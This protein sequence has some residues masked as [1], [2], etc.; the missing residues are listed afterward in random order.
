MRFFSKPAH[1]VSGRD[2]P[3]TVSI[4]RWLLATIL[5]VALALR[6]L[7]LAVAP[8]HG[9]II[10][11]VEYNGIAAM[12]ND[13]RGW[14]WFAG[15]VW[16]RPPLYPLFLLGLYK[17]F[18]TNMVAFQLVQIG[19]SVATVWLLHLWSASLY[20]R[21]VGLWAAGLLAVA[22]P[23]VTFPTFL[24]SENLFLFLLVAAFLALTHAVS[25]RR[26][27]LWALG[28]GALL[29]CAALT[30][31]QIL[32]F[33]PL[34]LLWP[35][36]ACGGTLRE[37]GRV[38]L[39]LSPAVLLAFVV[40]IAPWLVRNATTY[41][42]PFIDST[43]GYN[44]YL[45]AMGAREEL[46]VN[47]TLLAEPNQAARENLA[48]GKGLEKLRSDPAAFV[49]K[50]VK[51]FGDFWRLN[52]GADENLT[53]GWSH[54]EVGALWLGLNLV[55]GDLFYI[56]VGALAVVGLCLAPDVR[57]ARW[58]VILWLL[59]N[60]ALAFVF[61]ATSRFRLATF[62]VL[63]VFAA[64]TLANRREVWLRLKNLTGKGGVLHGGKL[65]VVLSVAF[66]FAFVL[67][68]G[69]SL[70]GNVP[71]YMTAFDKMGAHTALMRAESQRL[72][73]QPQTALDTL[74]EA[75]PNDPATLLS[76][77]LAQAQL[78]NYNEADT[79]AHSDVAVR[80]ILSNIV[81]G[82]A[83]RAQGKAAEERSAFNNRGL[84]SS[85][86]GA[87]P[88][89]DLHWAYVKAAPLLAPLSSVTLDGIGD[90]GYID[91]F[92]GAEKDGTQPFRWTAG[93][94]MERN[95]PAR[96]RLRLTADAAPQKV[97]IVA[98]AFR[99]APLPQPMLDVWVNGRHVGTA[100]MRQT[101][102]TL[103]FDLPP[104]LVAAQPLT[105]NSRDVV[106]EL[107][108]PVFVVGGGEDRRE[109][110]VAVSRVSLK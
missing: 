102:Q 66:T 107:R 81:Q 98:R 82:L 51:E 61:F 77:A 23:F 74:K 22:W 1:K 90:W 72:A 92:W 80:S 69:S 29:G 96:V 19:L 16:V 26:R 5:A 57:G 76:R 62:F 44:F 4:Y 21:R 86:A 64:W 67:L 99:P 58:L 24:L 3:S 91:T 50:G 60:M 27:L 54:G 40:V 48:Y 87:K 9:F 38:M 83:A 11:E 41:G 46:R 101:W 47:Q 6:L 43:G 70:V 104:G 20:G 17:I 84:R 35:L 97:E 31:G 71:L 93:P 56:V 18:G 12:L 103:T 85:D 49:N 108:S 65:V 79:L 15:S 28:G 53:D 75:D 52:F 13:G 25:G 89:A 37:R 78:S 34:V 100:Q 94:G 10:D 73:G 105:A 2:T 33:M 95:D 59:H 7:A 30:R 42:R 39:R 110:G 106:I 88:P 14:Q 36:L 55:L 63:L 32:S 8:P 45:G 109:L 68:A